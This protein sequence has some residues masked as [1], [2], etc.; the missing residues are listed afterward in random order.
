LH[1][2]VY[3]SRKAKEGDLFICLRGLKQDGHKFAPQAYSQGCRAFL[4]EE[5]LPLAEDATQI[6]VAD[7]RSA[8]QSLAAAFWGY[9][10]RKLKLVGI[11]GTNG[12]TTTSYLV[13]SI[14]HAAGLKVGLVG[15][16]GNLI[17][18]E[19]IPAQHTTPE[20]PDLQEMLAQMAERGL[21]H[22]VM[23]VSSHAIA[24]KRIS[25]GD[26]TVGVFTNLTQDHL[27]YHKTMDAYSRVKASFFGQLP[28][29]SASVLN[30]D[31]PYHQLMAEASP[32]KLIGYSLQAGDVQGEILSLTK[33]G[34][35]LGI[36][37]PKWHRQVKLALTGSFNAANSLAAAGAALA[38]G[39][40][41]AAICRGLSDLKGVPGRF[42][43]V[44]SGKPTVIVDYAHTPDGLA[45]VLSTARKLPI[46][47]LLVVFGCGGDRDRGK[48]PQMGKIAGELADFSIVTS[49]N[50]RSEDPL[51]I[52][53][54]V[55]AGLAAT[56][57]EYIVEPD[58]KTAIRRAITMAEP[59][60]LVLIAGK[61]HETYQIF[62]AETI[63]F[64][65]VQVAAQCLKEREN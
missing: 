55:E 38:L 30:L 45:N 58:R 32:G 65:D 4:T 20:A 42:Q 53:A 49:D 48:R 5:K 34:M 31:D 61:G 15:T 33:E 25:G 41:Q 54:E 10:A 62:R 13:R 59:D 7:T 6:V 63:H 8:M 43:R 14:L 44:G 47:R 23:E 60:D 64:D 57:G 39:V 3:D 35:L 50:P 40:D 22:V 46:G 36:A 18:D 17:A 16:I 11:T 26:F 2:L 9:P 29:D 52:C 28:P 12:K 56:G 37:T 21:T 27:D 51:A 1:G 19:F 24:Q